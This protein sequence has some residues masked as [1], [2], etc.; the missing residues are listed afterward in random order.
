[1]WWNGTSQVWSTSSVQRGTITT[2]CCVSAAGC[3]ALPM[4]TR[5]TARACEGLKCGARQEF[6]F[7]LNSKN[8]YVSKEYNFNTRKINVT[9]RINLHHSILFLESLD[10]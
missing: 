10:G 8:S 4:V 5:K 1:M 9:A 2:V 6:C 7:A 3:H